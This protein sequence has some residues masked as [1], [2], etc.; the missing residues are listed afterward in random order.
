MLNAVRQ[1]PLPRKRQLSGW[2]FGAVSIPLL[3]VVLVVARPHLALPTVMLL[4]LT[5][6]VATASIG[7]TV[8]ALAAAVGSFLIVNWYFTPPTHTWTVAET[9]HLID[10]FVFLV[11][12]GVVSLFVT[13]ANH[14]ALAA[15]RARA[16]AETLASLAQAGLEPDP[17]GTILE[18]L[19]FTFALEG[20][21]VL[22]RTGDRWAVEAFA[23]EHALATP[24]DA[25]WSTSLGDRSRLAVSGHHLDAADQRVLVAFAA[26]LANALTGLRLRRAAAGAEALERANELR[27]ALLAAVSHDLRTPLA[28][29]KACVTSLRA[30][31]VS[32]SEDVATQFLAT[33]EE[34]TDRL[35]G[36]VGN[37]LDMSRIQT[38]ALHLTQR[39]VGLEEVVPGALASLG[40]QSDSVDVDRA[41][42]L[43]QVEADPGLLERA[44]ANVVGN[45]TAWSPPSRRVRLEA[46][47]A[48]GAVELRVIDHG[49]GIPA[50]DR[51]RVFHPFQRLGDDRHRGGVGLGLAVSRGFIEA[52]HGELRIENTPGGGVTMVIRL[53]L[54]AV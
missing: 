7:G 44:V 23:G 40:P 18:R 5:L 14:Q 20:A 39:A 21:A 45:A 11:V 13:V 15:D 47:A 24:E 51:E 19:R 49:P 1:S 48:A 37:L 22:Q 54:A 38:G 50:V 46:S 4:F 30:E 28:S 10:L 3:A 16:E 27:T 31:D 17:I 33:I 41:E 32:W 12:A 42:T 36:L 6:V 43:P 53:P 34:E 52:M 26:Q 9:S 8:P 29:I 25:D 2:L 35:N